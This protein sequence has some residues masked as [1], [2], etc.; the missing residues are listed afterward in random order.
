M[1][2]VEVT[3]RLHLLRFPV[4]NAYLWQDPDGLTLIDCGVP[5]SGP[6]IAAAIR[7]LGHTPGDVRRLVLT[8]FHEDHVGSAAEIVTWGDVAVYAHRAD[9][10]FIS[11]ARPGPAPVL[12]DWEKPI[13][14]AVHASMS[15]VRPVPVGVSRELE[16]GDTVEFGGGALA[17][18]VPGHTPGS[19]ALYLPA[20]RVLF[21]GDTIAR[22]PD[23]TVML[24]VFNVD[25][26]EA[27]ASLRR[28]AGLDAEI[29]C[30]GHGEPV[31]SG[32]AAQLRAVAEAHPS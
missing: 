19:V 3:A 20:A 18:S 24:G 32:A 6:S 29:A 22:G 31:T 25:T 28:Q 14:D 11:G 1:D 17:L 16:H 26:T 10:P 4:G 30:F 9:A 15:D 21:T 5:G 12:R 27:V 23:G 8:H 2:V 7:E 13:W